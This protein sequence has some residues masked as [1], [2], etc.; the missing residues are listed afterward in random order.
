LGPIGD[1]EVDLVYGGEVIEHLWPDDVVGFL[2]EAHRVLRV[3]GT[4]ALDSPNR[5]ITSASDWLHPEHTVEFTPE[6]IAEALASAGFE[7][8]RVR[9]IWLTYDAE[10]HK[11]LPIEILEEASEWTWQHR[12]EAAE[13]R[14]ADSFIWWAEATK[15]DATR[16]E[17]DE[18]RL[19]ETIWRAFRTYRA[20]RF[21]RFQHHTGRL[22]RNDDETIVQAGPG[23]AGFLVA[24]PYV[25]MP[26]GMWM[27]RFRLGLDGPVGN[28]TEPVARVDVTT[29]ID[30]E[31]R[32]ER[33]VT[34]GE[35][36]ADGSLDEVDLVFRLERTDFATQFRVEG[37]GAKPISAR[38]GVEVEKAL[39][40]P[41]PV[42]RA[43]PDSASPG[44]PITPPAMSDDVAL[45][46]TT[47]GD[48]DKAPAPVTLPTRSLGRRLARL[49]LWPLIRFFDP[50]FHGLAAQADVYGLGLAQQIDD[51]RDD[52][53]AEVR[54]L[55]WEAQ[56]QPIARL[57]ALLRVDME[58][59]TEATAVLGQSVAEVREDVAR[60]QH[61]AGPFFERYSARTH[62]QFPPEVPWSEDYVLRHRQFVSEA[63]ENDDLVN[64]FAR[65][66]QLP[67]GYGVGLEERVI[68]YPWTYAQRLRG[69]ALDA[70]SSL[71]FAHILDLFQPKFERLEIVTLAPEIESFPER[72]VSYVYADLRALPFKSDYFETIVCISTLDHIGMDNAE[73]GVDDPPD[74]DPQAET[75]KALLELKRVIAPGGTV[76][77]T[78]PYGQSQDFGWSRQFGRPEL[79]E[80]VEAANARE[81]SISVYQ[82]DSSGWQLSNLDEAA[83]ARYHDYKENPGPTPDMVAAARAVACVRLEF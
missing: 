13:E 30:P 54:S 36:P 26:A 72:G 2:L 65:G 15:G 57:D 7:N 12:V 60:L 42:R 1:E 82:Y 28:P 74:A 53:R 55:H 56:A 75:R 3:G 47:P 27:V 66:E 31:Q 35:L 61:A 69:R 43:V 63:L 64:L 41:R 37:L 24:G 19:T 73:Y 79:L 45:T 11:L 52:L 70:G 6:E 4:I 59:T 18:E 50:R 80:L 39:P 83:H 9:G 29:G 67:R 33:V 32:A 68:E 51:L 40:R 46:G 34:A 22:V 16:D 20:F 78:V 21:T 14:P 71:N 77:F 44:D 49:A 25:P 8:V 62:P 17:Q 58:T 10:N 23:E 38:L 76:L 48:E 5:R 81:S